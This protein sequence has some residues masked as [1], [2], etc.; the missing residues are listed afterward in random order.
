MRRI[1]KGQLL[2]VRGTKDLGLTPRGRTMLSPVDQ[3]VGFKHP[4]QF[5]NIKLE[6]IAGP[7][8]GVTIQFNQCFARKANN[9]PV[10]VCSAYNWPHRKGAG[11]CEQ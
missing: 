3:I 4:N 8:K 2:I 7:L 10:C 9:K 6:H 5:L 11:K 1:A